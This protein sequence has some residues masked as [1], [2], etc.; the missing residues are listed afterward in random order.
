MERDNNS[1]NISSSERN[2]RKYLH[3]CFKE[4]LFHRVILTLPPAS[5]KNVCLLRCCW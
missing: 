2:L 5:K 4:N 3:D 1:T